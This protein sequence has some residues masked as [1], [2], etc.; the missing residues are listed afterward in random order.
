MDL[1]RRIKGIFKGDRKFLS[2]VFFILLLI[3]FIG[4]F[5]PYHITQITE[6]WERELNSRIKISQDEINKLIDEKEDELIF[7]KNELKA[8]LHTT[9]NKKSYDYGKLIS[10]ITNSSYNDL[11]IEVVAPNGRVIAWNK[12]SG[13]QK[14]E[15]FPLSYPLNET[16]FETSNLQ[17]LLALTDTI[18][19]QNDIFYLLINKPVEKLY[20]LQNTYYQNLSLQNDL[21][22]ELNLDVSLKYDP[23]SQPSKD[24]RI[25]SFPI[26]NKS[27]IKIGLAE[28]FKPSLNTVISEIQNFSSNCQTILIIVLTFIIGFSFKSD[29]KKIKSN[30]VKLILIIIYFAAIRVVIFLLNFPSNFLNSPI[31]EPAYFSSTFA[32]GIIKSPVEMFLT[33]MFVL[34]ISVLV[35]RYVK[36]YVSKKATSSFRILKLAASPA[37]AILS[38]YVIRGLAASVRSIIFD[39]TIRYFK[40]PDLLPSLPSLLMNLN[41]LMLGF[42]CVTVVVSFLYLITEFLNFFNEQRNP[43]RYFIYL[44]MIQI[45]AYIFF[46]MLKQPLVTEFMV[47]I[48]ICLI[49]VVLYRL[50]L[51]KINFASTFILIAVISSIISITLLNYFNLKL[52]KNS[53]RTIAYEINRT[54]EQFLQF[55][56]NETLRNSL[57]EPAVS[58]SFI[59]RNVNH[60]AQAFII[61]SKSPLQRESLNSSLILFDRNKSVL[62]SFSVGL[63]KQIN[64]FDYF[65]HPDSTVPQILEIN[66]ENKNANKKIIGLVALIRDNIL[67]GYIGVA[68][69]LDYES[70]GFASYPDFLE[71]DKA[72]LGSVVDLNLINIFEFVNGQVTQVYGDIFPSKEQKEQI[73]NA[74]LSQFN[75]GWVNL[76]LYSENYITFILK[77]I[78]DSGEKVTA[79]AVREKQFTWNLFN[80]FKIFIIHS[81]F[82]LLLFLVFI[83]I[84]LIRVQYTFRVKLL[85]TFLVISVIPLVLLAI[86]NRQ[87]ESER[88]N[89]EIFSEL[90]SQSTFLENHVR[91][92]IDKN[93]GRELVSAFENAGQELGIAFSVYEFSDQLYNSKNEFYNTGLFGKKL[94]PVVHFNLNYL[95]YREILVKEKI[96]K[97]IYDAY[98]RKISINNKSIILA[99]NDAFNKIKLTYSTA[100]ID[101]FLFGVYSFAVIIII[102]VSTLFANQIAAPIRRLTKATEAV[103][104][105]DLSIKLE[106]SEKG[107]IGDLFEGF[108][109]M[110]DELQKNQSEIAELER[111]NAWKEMA[112]Q[113][114]HEIKNPLTPMKLSVQQILASYQDKKENFG[115]ILKKLSQSVLNQI[116]NLS[117]IASEFSALAKMP[118]LKLEQVELVSIIHD[119]VNL[120]SDE[121]IKINFNSGITEVYSEADKSQFRR[122]LINLI[123]NSMQAHSTAIDIL[124]NN[125]NSVI[126]ILISDN[127]VGIPAENHEKIFETSFTTKEMGMGLGLKLAKRFIEG[128]GGQIILL[129]SNKM[130]TTFKITLTE[131]HKN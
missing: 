67:V 23:Y 62:G 53:I 109:S 72:V 59:K 30:S 15:I 49:G 13:N 42:A 56:I 45:A 90:S 111:E 11:L 22:D 41:L 12:P 104:K 32:G 16:H 60:D 20:D 126:E 80:F 83:S 19:I 114:A 18:K 107:E 63:N 3:L 50:I 131:S 117:L 29:F 21:T 85:V 51:K 76:S 27:G 54:D 87:V 35:F 108:N 65:S 106:E 70:F 48:F 24:G 5:T 52:E 124:M 102:I 40:E 98:Y 71:S 46:L 38:F 8:Q 77:E 9:L 28:F 57:K 61:W 128:I 130:G 94:N 47:F 119:T 55:L 4:L 103:A 25:F 84:K 73:F 113:V 123:R 2:I 112:K 97:F 66:S 125:N 100:D 122:M 75:D 118:S 26:L 34:I 121:S 10:S 129:S 74:K 88:T 105:G 110:T 33:S 44:L 89:D 39:S 115:E 14:K 81:V 64:F 1:L 101:V 31:T 78:K 36:L 91:A 58:E 43:K 99:V 6:N 127:G 7:R 120:F 37:L 86:Y 68:A 69:E 95:S 92:Q 82:I 79:V 17:T 93:P 96:D 116:E